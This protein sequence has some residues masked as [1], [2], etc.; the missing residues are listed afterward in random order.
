MA[1]EHVYSEPQWFSGNRLSAKLAI[2]RAP[3][4]RHSSV[5]FVTGQ[6]DWIG[7]RTEFLG[8]VRRADKPT[9]VVYGDRHQS[10]QTPKWRHSPSC[11]MFELSDCPKASCRSMKNFLKR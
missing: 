11:R 7:S 9:L 4:A 8:L 3:G 6:L 5:R 10:R 2:T 1:R